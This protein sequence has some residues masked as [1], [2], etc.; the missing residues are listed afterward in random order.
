MTNEELLQITV[1]QNLGCFTKDD[2][3]DIWQDDEYAQM[4]DE[5]LQLMM[6]FKLCY[7]IPGCPDTYIA[8]Q[9]LPIEKAKYTWD[10]SKNLILCYT[11]QSMI[12]KGM[13]TRFIVEMHPWI[14][15]QKLVWKSGVVLNKDQT[16]AE[17]IENYNQREIKIR[18]AGNR[19]KELMAVVT[20]ELEKINSSQEGLQYEARVPCNCE[21]CKNLP[22]PHFYSLDLLKKRLNASHYYIECYESYKRVDV[23][24]LIDDDVMLQ[25]VKADGEN[26]PEVTALESELERKPDESFKT[27]TR[28]QV[29]ISYSHKD[30][31]W[32]SKLQDCL[33][34]IIRNQ[35]ELVVWDD[36]KIKA[37]DQ[38][39]KEIENAL[40]LAKV[41]V[42]LVSHNFLASDFIHEN[43]LPP[44]LD[45]A[46]A[47]GLT[48]IWIPL[49]SSNYQETEINKYQ[50]AHPPNQPLKSL[51]SAQE[52]EAWVDICQKIKKAVAVPQ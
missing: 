15:Q 10:N 12:P 43:E 39:R 11:Y 4:R 45:A 18:V 6:R 35:K 24:S 38:W 17:V 8:P 20:H 14:E 23:R 13:F 40:A 33:K 37:G 2:L 47:K 21:T 1:N 7:K 5:L 28:N 42:L 27:V 34:P 9:F 52:D 22:K 41:A 26:N 16:R 3:K 31:E 46:K 32:L 48:I 36:T 49:S 19:K 29:F 30:E 51:S 25:P 50:S 44:L